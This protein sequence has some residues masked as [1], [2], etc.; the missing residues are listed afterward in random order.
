MRPTLFGT[1]AGSA[2]LPFDNIAMT[3][4]GLWDLQKVRTDYAGDAVR[5]GLAADSG[6]TTLDIGFLADGSFDMAAYSAFGTGSERIITWYDQSG[7][8]FDL[9]RAW[10]AANCPIIRT[11]TYNSKPC[12]YFASGNALINA[13]FTDWNGLADV[14]LFIARRLEGPGS[15][16]V[17]GGTNSNSYMLINTNRI[18]YWTI[19]GSNQYYNQARTAGALDRYQFQGSGM[20]RTKFWENTI[21]LTADVEA[22]APGATFPNQTGLAVNSIP[23]GTQGS[24]LE[25]FAMYYLGQSLSDPNVTAINTALND[26]YFTFTASQIACCGDSLTLNSAN[27]G[28]AAPG[29]YPNVLDTSLSSLTGTTWN[30]FPLA[31]SAEAGA[32]TARVLQIIESPNNVFDQ[33]DTHYPNHIVVAWAGTNDI[34]AG[35]TAAAALTGSLNITTPAYARGASV[36]Y[37]NMLPRQDLGAGNA[38]FEASRLTYNAGLAAALGAT[39]TVVDVAGIAQLQDPNDTNYYI[40]D[41]VHLND[42]G[43]ALVA[44]V[45]AAAIEA[46]IA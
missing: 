20:P 15:G 2:G 41:K 39:A 30:L 29:A 34:G 16:V 31:S 44:A 42:A 35:G 19:T 33:I 5:V 23:D 17:A 10:S 12:V 18:V 45:V 36:Y 38:A 27:G 11:S 25:C 21:A 37:L 14:N 7:N 6:A 46:D 3:H 40:S 4:A 22:S 9:S 13:G 43:N 28:S 1:V 32:A 24:S 8:G 26:S